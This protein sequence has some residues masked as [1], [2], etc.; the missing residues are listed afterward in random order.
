MKTL[1]DLLRGKSYGVFKNTNGEYCQVSRY[2]EKNNEKFKI[3]F[4]KGYEIAKRYAINTSSEKK[5]LKLIQDEN[6]ELVV[7]E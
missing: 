6:F 7:D 5:V 4:S 3:I 1:N 2:Y